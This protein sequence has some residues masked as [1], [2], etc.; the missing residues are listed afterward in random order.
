[1][2]PISFFAKAAACVAVVVGLPLVINSGVMFVISELQRD[3]AFRTC[4]DSKAL[5]DRAAM[6]EVKF[7]RR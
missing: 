1:M 4:L 3:M 6:M 7:C 5:D 2:S